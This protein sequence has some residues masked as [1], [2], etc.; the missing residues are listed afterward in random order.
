MFTTGLIQSLFVIISLI[1]SIFEH[2]HENHGLDPETG[3]TIGIRAMVPD[4]V[5]LTV[6]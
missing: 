4:L 3:P 6:Y 1:S 5:K 2:E